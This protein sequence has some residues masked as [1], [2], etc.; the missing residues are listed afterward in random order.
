MSDDF[1]DGLHTDLVE[2]MGRYEQRGRLAPA[3]PAPRPAML[4]RL[5]A[6]AAAL[7]AVVI[8]IVALAP[9]PR[10]ARPHVVATLE[11]GGTPIDAA[12]GDGS[13]W[14]T[15]F[16]G[17][18]V[19]I[20]P[21]ARRV[22]ARTEVPGAPGPVTT[23]EGSVWVQTSGKHCEGSLLRIDPSSGRIVS[24]TRHAYPFDGEG[25]GALA[26]GGGA[27]WA[28]R[29]C[30]LGH[31][32]IDR[33]DPAG[34]V[35]GGATLPAAEG[36]AATGGD[37]WVL[38]HEGTVTLLDA[39]TGRVRQRWPRL[40]PLADPETDN[41]KALAAFRAGVWVLSTGRHALLG[42]ERG[43]VVRRLPVPGSAR[44]LLAQ[45]P[46]GLWIATADR[47]GADNRLVRIDAHTGST[48][49]TLELGAQQPV[50]LVPTDGQLCV[51]TANG[52]I[53]FV[54]S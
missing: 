32:G 44:P 51:L 28:R 42:I 19:S 33:L 34:V 2:A 20:D 41:T 15:D 53:L 40:A 35:T 31:E 1:I 36:L 22:I 52:R 6:V 24:R 30:A 49:A 54:G 13:L 27:I 12:V 46:D 50:A 26:F 43:R 4:V 21:V 39:S 9:S 14:A 7:V 45:T 17:S 11:I 47:L 18:I 8:A 23:G 37:L 16:T 3:L 38:G 48:T 29:G 10:P 5:A 25:V